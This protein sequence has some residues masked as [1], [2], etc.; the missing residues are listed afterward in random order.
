M[1][2]KKI[3]EIAVA[4]IRNEIYRND[5]L[6]D[7]IPTNDK[8]P[9]WDGEIWVFNTTEQRKS[10]LYGKVPVQ[11]KGKK[12]DKF[13]DEKTK[14]PLNKSDLENYFTN[15]GIL[16]FVVEIIDSD[17]TQIF[18]QSFLPVDI[19][20]ILGEMNRQKTI[21]KHFKKLSPTKQSL[22]YVIRNF[23]FNS[24]KQSLPLINDVKVTDF[25]DY[26]TKVLVPRQ[27]I[28]NEHLFESDIYMY[29]HKN[30]INL[31]IPLYKI[32]I[33][34][35]TETA[36]LY[37]GLNNEIFY[38]EVSR[39][40]ERNKKTLHFGKS[41]TLDLPLNTKT[42][43]QDSSSTGGDIINPITIKI[44]FNESG[45]IQDRIKD[46]SFMLEVIR[47]K[48]IEINDVEISLKQSI[49]EVDDMAKEL[50]AYI[51]F[52]KEVSDTFKE[53]RVPF[54]IDLK[55]L[56]KRDK[57]N[58]E[59]LRDVILHKDYKELNL[60]KDHHFV[61]FEI[62][63]VNI[64]LVSIQTKEGWLVF[65]AFD[66]DAISNH[67]KIVAISKDG[68][69]KVRHTPFIAF[70]VPHLFSMNNLKLSA[71]EASFKQVDYEHGMS[72]ELTNNFLLNLLNYYDQYRE[73]K[74]ILELTLNL[75][76]HISKL[77]PDNILAFIN[78]MQTI[79][80]MRNFTTDEKAE[81]INRKNET[82]HSDEILC[83]FHILL[84]SKI[85]FEFQFSKLSP[86]DQETFK[87]YPIYHLIQ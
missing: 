20:K 56:T 32:E 52:L 26:R 37:I 43:T 53:L 69:T 81:I 30:D 8:T 50:P 39:V 76:E 59:L 68:K 73:K 5:Y 45:T 51:N 78:K 41:F 65:D 71:I 18:Y 34:A 9:S 25:D 85:E 7:E 86:E 64:L 84:D 66:I 38:T 36:D 40:I 24:R 3:E 29:G 2:T 58:M 27:A 17:H 12:V 13:S 15:G 16:F 61:R 77:Q 47:N 57:R 72:F 10:D 6:S 46:C 14:F 31:D 83:G 79:K 54:E 80:R 75:F 48:K 1:N 23:I 35:I 4:A 49:T 70:D 82:Q 22:E 62:A 87:S 28:H 19:K 74:G 33:T 60:K 63:D 44:H 21:T 42:V 11:V 55:N 67:F